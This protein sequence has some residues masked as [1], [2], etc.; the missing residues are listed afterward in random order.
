MSG[1]KAAILVIVF[2]LAVLIFGWFFLKNVM[3]NFDVDK[4][5]SRHIQSEAETIITDTI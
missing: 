3:I 1:K 4:D 5:A 2:T